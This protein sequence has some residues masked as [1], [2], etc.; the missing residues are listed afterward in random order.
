M[1]QVF[2]Y[3]P[4][5]GMQKFAYYLLQRLFKVRNCDEIGSKNGKNA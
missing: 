2:A 5:R 3:F 1:S 4:K